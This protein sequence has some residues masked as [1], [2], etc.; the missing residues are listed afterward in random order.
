MRVKP[1]LVFFVLFVL[2]WNPTCESVVSSKRVRFIEAAN[3]TPNFLASVDI[4][5][6][7]PYTV[8]FNIAGRG[9][10]TLKVGVAL[11]A[12][13]K[14]VSIDRKLTFFTVK[15]YNYTRFGRYEDVERKR[16]ELIR[17]GFNVTSDIVRI[18]RN[19]LTGEEFPEWEEVYGFNETIF[20]V[21]FNI[22]LSEHEVVISAE[23]PQEGKTE[24]SEELSNVLSSAIYLCLISM[25]AVVL[26]GVYYITIV[27]N[28]KL[29]Y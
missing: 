23:E 21:G 19:P 18:Y 2:L 13:P 24:T 1:L 14:M 7:T 11:V 4:T 15:C 29:K 3:Q 8:A 6:D 12:K 5:T 25:I 9:N 28:S 10:A 20:L 27:K 22:S 17:G 26:I 16:E